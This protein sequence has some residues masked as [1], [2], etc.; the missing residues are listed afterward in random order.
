MSA[1]ISALIGPLISAVI[2]GL[3]GIATTWL[4]SQQDQAAGAVQASAATSAATAQTEVKIA[5][6][7]AQAPKT[8]AA[9]VSAFEA[10]D[11]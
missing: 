1:I 9:A 4:R 3:L 10:G 7:E 8:Q 11:V 6:A 2:T 5:Q